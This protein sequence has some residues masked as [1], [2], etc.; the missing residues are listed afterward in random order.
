VLLL[1]GIMGES[2]FT[3]VRPGIVQALRAAGRRVLLLDARGHGRSQKPHDTAAYEHDAMARD[4]QALL[5]HLELTTV[6][7]VGYSMGAYT[8]ARLVLRD[9]RPR[10]LVLGG[11]GPI[12]FKRSL[13]LT[14]AIAD[15]LEADDPSSIDDPEV[16][17]W[18]EHA[19]AAGVDRLA[20]AAL[21]R[22]P[23]VGDEEEL[24]RIAV[25]AIVLTGEQDEVAGSG[26]ELAA[27]IPTAT[28]VIVPGSHF[29]KADRALDQPAFIGAV[30]EF[31][32]ARS[33]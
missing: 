22:A 18:R 19:D 2:H 32:A 5:D 1:H 31:L 20:I 21:F 27:A 17:A 16:L 13:A 6:D 26:A 33:L 10:S 9:P 25:P 15:A 29:P 14:G 4:C 23:R 8:G 24:A 3:W 28:A 12:T 11:A 30:L 7:V